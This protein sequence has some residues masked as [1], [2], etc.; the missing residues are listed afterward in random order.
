MYP[1]EK[2]DK[3]E[4]I[5]SVGVGKKYYYKQSGRKYR[6]WNYMEFWGLSG[7][8]SE[9]LNRLCITCFP[10]PWSLCRTGSGFCESPGGWL[11]SSAGSEKWWSWGSAHYWNAAWQGWGWRHEAGE[12]REI[13]RLWRRISLS[14]TAGKYGWKAKERT[15]G[16]HSALSSPCRCMV[17]T[18]VGGVCITPCPGGRWAGI[19]ANPLRAVKENWTITYHGDFGTRAKQWISTLRKIMKRKFTPPLLIAPYRPVQSRVFSNFIGPGGRKVTPIWSTVH[20]GPDWY[21]LPI[22]V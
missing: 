3:S 18:V 5:Q 2:E 6:C 12:G 4:N 1:G 9:S 11:R 16:V 21:R 13:I 8:M 15:E 19:Y 20:G 10:T 14:S 7:R 22:R 17:F